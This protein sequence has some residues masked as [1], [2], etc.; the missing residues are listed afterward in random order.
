MVVLMTVR[1]ILITLIIMPWVEEVAVEMEVVVG[2]VIAVS[3][4]LLRSISNV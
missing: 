2:V 1:T 4:P 3:L